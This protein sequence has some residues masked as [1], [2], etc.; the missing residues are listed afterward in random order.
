MNPIENT[1]FNPTENLRKDFDH[2]IQEE[3]HWVSICLQKGELSS[4]EGKQKAIATLQKV[5]TLMQTLVKTH[6]IVLEPEKPGSSLEP[7]DPK[8]KIREISSLFLLDVYLNQLVD[9][10]PQ[11][12]AVNTAKKAMNFANKALG[13][14]KEVQMS[15]DP[16]VKKVI[17]DIQ[18]ERAKLSD[19]ANRTKL[20][21]KE[22][23]KTF[24]QSGRT[25]DALHL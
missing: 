16:E 6:T 4:S 17:D 22:I 15:V 21:N 2:S 13:I 3:L 11:K 25:Q 14:E 7:L 20:S 19:P 12:K 23:I 24:I 18:R 8:A 1:P 10:L 9:S 5:H